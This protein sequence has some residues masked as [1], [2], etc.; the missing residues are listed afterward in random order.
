MKI[1][2][3]ALL[4]I[5]LTGCGFSEKQPQTALELVDRMEAEFAKVKSYT[6]D[7]SF[8]VKYGNSDTMDEV[9]SIVETTDKITDPLSMFSTLTNKLLDPEPTL[10]YLLNDELYE[11]QDGVWVK[12]P[13]S[14]AKEYTQYYSNNTNILS[15]DIKD[16]GFAEQDMV[17]TKEGDNYILKIN[18][19]PN[20][21]TD[22]E[23]DKNKF[24]MECVIDRKTL[25]P[26]KLT[27][28]TYHKEQSGNES[29]GVSTTIVE[30]RNY[31][32]VE[33][34]KLPKEAESAEVVPSE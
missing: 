16:N 11:F 26:V 9:I 23:D 32:K 10:T 33:E 24:T 31:N 12:R 3:L 17:M 21:S 2:V 19:I 5:S 8:S 14:D 27:K 6:M 13:E 18:M 4:A 15:S 29:D 20:S 25:L 30:Y 22:H 7:S 34:I 1:A 28:N